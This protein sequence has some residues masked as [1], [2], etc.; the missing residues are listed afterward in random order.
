MF[1]QRHHHRIALI[2]GV[3][4][5]TL[6]GTLA[7]AQNPDE[8]KGDPYTLDVCSVSGEKLGT[9]GDPFLLN[10]EGRDIRFCCAGC[11]PRF[12]NDPSEFLSKIDALMISAQKGHYPLD[13][14]IV[15]GDALGDAPID[16]V[17][18]NR[19]VRFSSQMSAQ[20]FYRSSEKY[21]AKLDEAVIA[22]QQDTYPLDTCIISGEKLTVMGEPI[23]LVAANQLVQF[24]CAGCVAQFWKNPVASLQKLHGGPGAG[25]ATGDD[26]GS[27]HK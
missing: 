10:H 27:D 15:S 6:V 2:L 12:E 5:L 25:H 1:T 20:K 13:T 21:L 22:A 11:K 14:D 9:M 4:A 8:Y 3:C 18:N 26:E 19:L 23:Q 17:H 24:C 7:I 16:I